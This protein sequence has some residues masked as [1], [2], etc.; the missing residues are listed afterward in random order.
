[1]RD[2]IGG[3]GLSRLAA[4]LVGAVLLVAGTLAQPA[5]VAE[6]EPQLLEQ[7][8]YRHIGPVGNRVS[9]VVGVPG[10]PNIYYVG[11]ASG[12][13]FKSVDGGVHWEP[14][15]DDQPAASIGALA[16]DPVNPNVI[17]AGTGE[18]F[19]RSNVSIGNGIYKST[20]RVARLRAPGTRNLGRSVAIGS[21][22]VL[23]GVPLASGAQ[24][25]TGEVHVFDAR[26]D[27]RSS[28]RVLSL[29]GG[30]IT[31]GLGGSVA[32][33]AGRAIVG[34]QGAEYEGRATGLAIVYE[35]GV[36][37]WREVARLGPRWARW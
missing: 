24:R 22:D 10:D 35:R 34:A 33:A 2:S 36:R 20:E 25:Y 32:L 3:S 14:V 18:T 5:G 28:R 26:G 19:I 27:S 13:I 7:L 1:M 15:F 8:V 16:I 6:L 29:G 37:D 17:W 21:P 9:A 12:G 23:V 30:A 4:T 11:A 31:A